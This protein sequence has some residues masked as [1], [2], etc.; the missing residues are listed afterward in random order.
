MKKKLL[1]LVLAALML[2]ASACVKTPEPSGEDY[3]ADVAAA[4]AAIAAASYGPL[5]QADANTEAAAKTYV[6]GKLG[7]LDLK[8]V[9]AEVAGA[10]TAATAGTVSNLSGVDGSYKFTVALTKGEAADTTGQITL[11]ITATEYDK[12]AD[13]AAVAA[14]K[15]AV[16]NAVYGPAAQS[17]GNSET[18]SKTYVEGIIAALNL[19]GATAAVDTVSF[20][21]AEA[22]TASAQS[23]VDG[24][25]VFTVTLTKGAGEPQTTQELTLT[26]TAAEYVPAQVL[27]TFV[28]NA[29]W[30]TEEQDPDGRVSGGPSVTVTATYGS[31]MP[32]G[33]GI[34]APTRYGYN[35][36]G[37]W[38]AKTGGKQYYTS[39]MT[40]ANSWD[41]ET[42][43]TLYA[44]W[45]AKS[46]ITV[47]FDRNGGTGTATSLTNRTFGGA[48]G[49]SAL[50]SVTYSGY[51]FGGWWTDAAREYDGAS[52]L[53]RAN[54]NIIDVEP[55]GTTI[56]LKARW[57][58]VEDYDF[59]NPY[60]N[61]YFTRNGTVMSHTSANGGNIFVSD[62]TNTDG[63]WIVFTPQANI[64]ASRT[65][66]FDIRLAYANGS[67]IVMNKSISITL[68][69]W[70]T[71][72]GSETS[73]G[74]KAVLPDSGTW[75]AANGGIVTLRYDLPSA[76]TQRVQLYINTTGITD[77]GNIR[78]HIHRVQN[79][80]TSSMPAKTLWDFTDSND[81]NDFLMNGN[82]PLTLDGNSVKYANTNGYSE[83]WIRFPRAVN[84][85]NT[86]SFN[87]K[88]TQP[89]TF[90]DI[91]RLELRSHSPEKS[92]G[93][94]SFTP[95]MSA[96][97][98]GEV[99]VSFDIAENVGSA[100]F[101]LIF[102][103]YS[104]GANTSVY[105]IHRA[106]I[107]PT[108]KKTA[109]DFSNL[110]DAA[111]FDK[112]MDIATEG[113][114]LKL[115]D[116]WTDQWHGG[117][118]NIYIN[119]WQPISAGYTVTF[120]ISVVPA[121]GTFSSPVTFRYSYA[122]DTTIGTSQS[123]SNN[124]MQTWAFAVTSAET[125]R[126]YL[127]VN[128]SGLSNIPGVIIYIHSVTI[129]PTV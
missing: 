40:S 27:L 111:Y 129:A 102:W 31:A 55:D 10:F 28:M 30:D 126:T 67:P 11:V 33:T 44:R 49:T 29:F 20:A 128:L 24:E 118:K 60:D 92:Y 4:K 116:F 113:G 23:G 123:V 21:A 122:N 46:G 26:I 96:A 103:N 104:S 70:Q 38:D 76:G 15:T 61:T 108:V 57:D 43:A 13:D 17:Q 63:I 14:A 77:M 105:S 121:S 98:S 1:A 53:I 12:A 106:E 85:G 125:A 83:V 2:F 119:F 35:F 64:A 19:D 50:P 110:N 62:P 36:S 127:Q 84:A 52:K 34:A 97:L 78:Y 100:G 91:F 124:T 99:T 51:R 81:I 88:L 115:Y 7:G 56:T 120:Q 58:S 114:K 6:Q 54:T 47:A 65:L 94:R 74:T 72:S 3:S 41:K 16:E 5:K 101:N 79:L 107:A 68:T 22:G 18:A 73:V 8:G 117:D 95:N 32:T 66:L 45:A 90:N 112:G 87:V 37:Y 25:Y 59:T 42:A 69:R 75:P 80:A 9:T 82:T 93:K 86:L 109:W 39:T 48:Y 89:G 71:A